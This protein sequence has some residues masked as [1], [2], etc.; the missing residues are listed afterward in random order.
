MPSKLTPLGK[1]APASNSLAPLNQPTAGDSD[2][3]VVYTNATA[4]PKVTSSTSV[5]LTPPASF[6]AQLMVTA[7]LAD[8][9]LG[10]SRSAAGQDV[11]YLD[12]LR[13]ETVATY[14]GTQSIYRRFPRLQVRGIRAPY[15]YLTINAAYVITERGKSGWVKEVIKTGP[16]AP[17]GLVVVDCKGVKDTTGQNVSSGMTQITITQ[18][19]AASITYLEVRVRAPDETILYSGHWGTPP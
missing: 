18:H 1:P 13:R 10:S 15:G 8:Q 6:Q 2:R 12:T 19:A 16:V 11:L 17:N 7:L 3:A 4:V 14:T 9:H 5:W